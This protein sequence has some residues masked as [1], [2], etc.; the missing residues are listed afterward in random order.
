MLLSSKHTEE[1]GGLISRD[2]GMD[3]LYEGAAKSMGG[4]RGRQP[5]MARW[6][7]NCNSF[8][9]TPVVSSRRVSHAVHDRGKHYLAAKSGSAR[10]MKYLAG[11]W[12]V[13]WKLFGTVPGQFLDLNNIR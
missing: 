9:S 12:Q 11:Y 2:Q 6:V 10:V 4:D 5:H 8:P 7:E 13:F 3:K 1:T